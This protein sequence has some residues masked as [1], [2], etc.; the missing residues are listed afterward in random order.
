MMDAITFRIGFGTSKKDARP[1]REINKLCLCVRVPEAC[2]ERS[3]EIMQFSGRINRRK[4]WRYLS[5]EV[6]IFIVADRSRQLQSI[7]KIFGQLGVNTK[8]INGNPL[9]TISVHRIFIEDG[10]IRKQVIPT[11]ISSHHH[12]YHLFYFSKVIVYLSMV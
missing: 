6:F 7:R 3:P 8:L 4:S 9:E 11:D 10:A 2:L 12:F 1:S 5:I